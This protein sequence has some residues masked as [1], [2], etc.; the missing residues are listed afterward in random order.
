[1]ISSN[2]LF[3]MSAVFAPFLSSI[4]LVATVE[5]WVILATFPLVML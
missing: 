4:A 2:P 3:V 5:P 1:M